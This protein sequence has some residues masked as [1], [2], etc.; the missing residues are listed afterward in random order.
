MRTGQAPRIKRAALKSIGSDGAEEE[1]MAKVFQ[2]VW[3]AGPRKVKRAAWGYTVQVDGKQ[4]RRFREEWTKDDVE[5]ALAA[6]QLG[7]APTP[8]SSPALMFAEAVDKYLLEKTAARKR[9]LR[10]DRMGCARLTAY[11]GAGTSLTEITAQRI[12]EYRV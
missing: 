3:R 6:R 9:S 4:E 12:G 7:L 1:L 11:F 2:R 5:K 8:A 10:N